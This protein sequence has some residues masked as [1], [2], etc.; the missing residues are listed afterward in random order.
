MDS[1]SWI[2]FNIWMTRISVFRATVRDNVKTINFSTFFQDRVIWGYLKIKPRKRSGL[3][4]LF[5]EIQCFD[6][7]LQVSNIS[8]ATRNKHSELRAHRVK[9]S[10]VTQFFYFSFWMYYIWLT[11]LPSRWKKSGENIIIKRVTLNS[12][13]R[14]H[15]FFLKMR[16]TVYVWIGGKLACENIRFSSLFAVGDVSRETSQRRRAR[17]NGCFRRLR[18]NDFC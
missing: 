18:E 4:V 2:F 10:R 13:P 6:D 1:R 17:R 16:I 9:T 7:C 8:G 14:K 5:S 11:F 15:T 3:K 12:K